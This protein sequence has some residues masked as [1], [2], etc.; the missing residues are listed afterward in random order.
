MQ[1]TGLDEGR[2]FSVANSKGCWQNAKKKKTKTEQCW[3]KIVE[4]NNTQH[5]ATP[6]SVN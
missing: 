3:D 4:N 2:S 5:L 6:G 1:R